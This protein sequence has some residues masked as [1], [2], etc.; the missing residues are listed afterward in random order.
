MKGINYMSRY[1][2][3]AIAIWAI[4]GTLLLRFSFAAKSEETLGFDYYI[5]SLSWSP[6]F[7]KEHGNN[8]ECREPHRFILHGLWPQYEDGGYPS[9]C[10]RYDYVEE[11]VISDMMQYMPNR[12]LITHEWQKHGTCTGL[13]PAQYF[14]TA[15]N[16][17]KSIK[18][19]DLFNETENFQAST[20][21]IIDAFKK[22]NPTLMDGEIQVFCP[23]NELAEVRFP[24]DK[25]GSFRLGDEENDQVCHSDH[26]HITAP[27]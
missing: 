18:V 22:V 9:N 6:Q 4:L 10:R 26:V 17:Y 11:S 13:S 2:I 20:Q 27:N 25:I 19:P 21:Q 14:G 7:C 24:I 12:H 16:A 1:T 8:E 3:A 5:L 15:A 23:G